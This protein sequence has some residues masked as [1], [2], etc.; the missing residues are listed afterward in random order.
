MLRGLNWA[1]L[2]AGFLLVAGTI[3][4]EADMGLG[5]FAIPIAGFFVAFGFAPYVP[6]G[7]INRRTDRPVPLALC[8]LA[9]I[10][11]SAFWIWGFGSTFWW[12]QHPDAQDGLV[13][14]VLPVY[15]MAAAGIVAAGIW[16]IDRYL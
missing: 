14:I 1:L 12:N 8:A 9:M 13:L 16:A 7:I 6:F 4:S 15:M 3:F 2:A 5:V 11:L 10:A